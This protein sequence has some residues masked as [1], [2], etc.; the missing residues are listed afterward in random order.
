V[1]GQALNRLAAIRLAQHQLDRAVGGARRALQ[2]NLSAGY[3]LGQAHAHLILAQALDRVD[4]GS[5]DARQHQ[6]CADEL[7]EEI[8]TG[9]REAAGLNLPV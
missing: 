4:A 5:G 3:R 7:L 1:Q 8:G 6:A 2:V 9:T